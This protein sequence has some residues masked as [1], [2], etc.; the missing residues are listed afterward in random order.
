M[1]LHYSNEQQTTAIH[2]TATLKN[3]KHTE[4]K[5]N[6]PKNA[7]VAEFMLYLPQFTK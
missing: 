2:Q 7:D 1:C 3:I 6:Y 5:T 4:I